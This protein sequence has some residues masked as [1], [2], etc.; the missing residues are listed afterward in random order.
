[1]IADSRTRRARM[2]AGRASISASTRALSVSTIQAIY[3]QY[4]KNDMSLS[5]V[6]SEG[7]APGIEPSDF[8]PVQSDAR[9]S[10]WFNPACPKRA[11]QRNQSIIFAAPSREQTSR[12]SP[13]QRLQRRRSCP[14]QAV[15]FSCFCHDDQ[16]S[17]EKTVMCMATHDVVARIARAHLSAHVE[18]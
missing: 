17:V 5:T 6:I 9:R 8:S 2:S 10:W 12:I 14:V 3:W 13:S 11:A 1:M 18:V 15:L 7:F 16:L 4:I